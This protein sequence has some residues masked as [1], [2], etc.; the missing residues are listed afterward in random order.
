SFN[1]VPE[2][3][4][5]AYYQYILGG[6]GNMW[7]EYMPDSRQVEYMLLPRLTAL[8]EVLWHN[9]TERNF[10]AFAKNIPA[11]FERFAKAGFY[12][13]KALYQIRAEVLP[14]YRNKGLNV[15][16]STYDPEGQIFYT[17]DGSTPDNTASAYQQVLSIDSTTVVR[18]RVYANGKA[19]SP[20]FNK[21]YLFSKIT[22]SKVNLKSAAHPSYNMHGEFTLV[23]GTRGTL[24]W[25]GNEWLGFWGEDMEATIDYG[26]KTHFQKVTAGVLRDEG[27]WIYLPASME[28]YTSL[29]SVQFTFKGFLDASAIAQGAPYITV[30]FD[31]TEA[32]YIKIVLRNAGTISEGK[33]GAGFKAW[34][35]VDEI[36]AE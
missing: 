3:L 9:P 24:P 21:Q 32:R 15:M 20:E 26:S 2:V 1:P 34:L 11:H 8:A 7:T 31:A 36:L 19:Q 13:S 33:S 18:A 28:V 17:L 10:N 12:Y 29:D 23:D 22:A 25:K 16:L 5:T 35:F 14:D 4:D 30:S 27:S 6:Q